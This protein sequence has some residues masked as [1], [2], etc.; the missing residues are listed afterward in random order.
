MRIL[1]IININRNNKIIGKISH[2]ITSVNTIYVDKIDLQ[3]KLDIRA[4]LIGLI[5]YRNFTPFSV[6]RDFVVSRGSNVELGIALNILYSN[7]SVLPI[8]QA[9]WTSSRGSCHPTDLVVILCILIGIG[10]KG[11]VS[12]DR[13]VHAVRKVVPSEMFLQR[14]ILSSIESNKL[15]SHRT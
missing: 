14:D 12:E 13:S 1:R 11:I 9:L 7:H 4:F 8:I 5:D 15:I 3:I 2:I 6:I 10:S